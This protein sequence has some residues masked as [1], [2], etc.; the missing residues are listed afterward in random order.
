MKEYEELVAVVPAP[1]NP[2]C[3]NPCK[4]LM[5]VKT[6]TPKNNNDHIRDT[7]QPLQEI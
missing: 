3:P 4:L 5:P 2:A 7:R 6:T 1:I